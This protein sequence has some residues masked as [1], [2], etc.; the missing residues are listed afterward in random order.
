MRAI[1]FVTLLLIVVGCSGAPTPT[2]PKGVTVK[3]SPTIP[4][5][6][7]M[8]EEHAVEGCTEYVTLL[9]A[10]R[11]ANRAATTDEEKNLVNRVFMD[12]VDALYDEHLQ[13]VVPAVSSDVPKTADTSYKEMQLRLERDQWFLKVEA[14]CASIM[15]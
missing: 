5:S 3:P 9:E 4:A 13:Y 6:D 11:R 12:K 10:A 14:L 15:N 8:A 7:S 2:P 1:V